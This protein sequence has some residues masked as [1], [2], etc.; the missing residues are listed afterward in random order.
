MG[1]PRIVVDMETVGREVDQEAL[2]D[3]TRD[4]MAQWEPTSTW[5]ADTVE[6]KREE[7]QIKYEDKFRT[8]YWKKFYGRKILCIGVGVLTDNEVEDVEVFIGEEVDILKEFVGYIEGYQ[9]WNLVTYNGKG[10]DWPTITYVAALNGINIPHYSKHYDLMKTIQYE[11]GESY[12]SL[13]HAAKIFNIPRRTDVDGSQVAD[14]LDQGQMSKIE[15]YQKDDI[16]MTA[17]VAI[18]LNR[19][20]PVF[21]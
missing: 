18:A 6:R 19:A 14:L 17:G 7:A 13:K 4:Y 15:E 9:P 5:K 11:M 21:R 8:D 1:K 10:F 3:A 16:Y 12:M 20:L 2:V